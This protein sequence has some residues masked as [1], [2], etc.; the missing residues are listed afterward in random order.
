MVF[1]S[2]AIA[3]VGH[4]LA[5]I[6]T[7]CNP[8]VFEELLEVWMRVWAMKSFVFYHSCKLEVSVLKPRLDRGAFVVSCVPVM[9][10]LQDVFLAKP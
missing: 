1:I 8:I 7:H 2:V 6:A 10:F 3:F 9:F 5:A 4:I